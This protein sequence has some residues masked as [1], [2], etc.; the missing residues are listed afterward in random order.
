MSTTTDMTPGLDAANQVAALACVLECL[1]VERMDSH[2]LMDALASIAARL[3]R[4][5]HVVYFS[6]DKEAG[7]EHGQDDAELSRIL[8]GDI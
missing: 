2:A 6:I 5:S 1:S 7:L 3:K 8:R 4:L